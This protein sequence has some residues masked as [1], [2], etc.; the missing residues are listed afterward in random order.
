M[1][2]DYSTVDISFPFMVFIEDV[3]IGSHTIRHPTKNKRSFTA[4][5]VMTN[6]ASK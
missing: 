1:F 4:I 3:T 5:I 2:H 6:K